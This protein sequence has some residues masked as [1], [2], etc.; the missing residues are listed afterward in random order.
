MK[1]MKYIVVEDGF[2]IECPYIFPDH[3]QHYMMLSDIGGKLI[4]AGFIV[5]GVNGIECYGDSFSLK[6]KSRPVIDTELVNKML[7][8]Q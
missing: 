2:G 3:I 4:S 1:K 8:A 6:V 7:G 5:S